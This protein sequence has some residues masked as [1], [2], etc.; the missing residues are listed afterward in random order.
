MDTPKFFS[1][2]EFAGHFSVKPQTV[3]V[4]L[5]KHGHFLGIRPK[6]LPNRLL[7]WPADA[8]H[9]LLSGDAK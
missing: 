1:T 9:A 8:V 4:N 2:D 5:C 6:K 3:R 7:L